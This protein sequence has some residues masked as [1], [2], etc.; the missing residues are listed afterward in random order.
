MFDGCSENE[1]LA[2]MGRSS[3]MIRWR[4]KRDKG[5][6]GDSDTEHRAITGTAEKTLAA[7]RKHKVPMSPENYHVW[8]RYVEGDHKKLNVAIDGI[9]QTDKMFSSGVSEQLYE[10]FIKSG[11]HLSSL[12]Q[13]QRQAQSLLKNILNE[14]LCSK[15][16]ASSY[17]ND[18]AEYSDRLTNAEDLGEIQQLAKD[19]IRDTRMMAA[20]SFSLQERLEEAS[21]DAEKLR[22]ELEKVGKDANTD[23]LTGL[24]NRRS[25]DEKAS[26]LLRQFEEEGI[27]FSAIMID[28]DH[29]KKFNDTYGHHAGD[30][31]LRILSATLRR[32]LKGMD[33]PARYGGEEFLVLLPATELD[34]AYAVAEELRRLI[35]RNELKVRKTQRSIGNVTVSLGVAVVRSRDTIDSLIDRADRALYL[36]KDSG[37]NDVKSERDL[38]GSRFGSG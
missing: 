20:S 4:V 15:D 24:H 35:A 33:L 1:A 14:I 16:L 18:L 2:G 19:M 30:E 23:P 7:M 34:G 8:Y 12:Q 27:L 3:K 26:E 38:S 22:E 13:T 25:V 28:I 6:T 32:F 37:R 36:A 5:F 17:G 9:L 10:E 29:F 31:V 11:E 21:H